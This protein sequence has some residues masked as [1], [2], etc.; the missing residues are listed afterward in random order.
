M[1]PDIRD[2]LIAWVLPSS[3]LQAIAQYYFEDIINRYS[4]TR[5]VTYTFGKVGTHK[6]VLVNPAS[7][8]ENSGI[9]CLV[10][11]L[12][13]HVPSVRAGFLISSDAV[14]PRTG[15]ARIGDIVVGGTL[16]HMQRRIIR[17]DVE[18]TTNKKRL[19]ITGESR[20]MSPSVSEAV[21]YARSPE[22]L[23]DWKRRLYRH[24]GPSDERR[25]VEEVDAPQLAAPS[26]D[27]RKALLGVI[28]SSTLSIEDFGLLA[29]IAAERSILCFETTAA[30]IDDNPFLIVASID[31]YCDD[32]RGHLAHEET[33]KAVVSYLACLVSRIDHYK[34]A[35]EP[36]VELQFRYE[37]FDLGQPGF[38][39]LR[40]QGGTG[41]LQCHIFQAS[42]ADENIVPYEA[43]S[44]CWGSDRL[45]DAIQVNGRAFA[46]TSNLHLALTHLRLPD[47][48]RILWIDAICI[49]QGNIRERGHQ[50][51]H[52]GDVY[53]RAKNVLFWL[54]YVNSDIV[55]LFRALQKFEGRVPVDAWMRWH[56][57][58]T[59]FQGIWDSTQESSEDRNLSRS[60][61]Q[62]RLKSLISNEWFGRVW[63]IQ[64]VFNAQRAS[65]GCT[66][67]WVNARTFA[68]APILLEVEPSTQC[69]AIIDV[70]PGPS[71]RSS[72]WSQKPNLSTLLWKFRE[73]QAT[74]PRDRVFALL[75]ICADRPFKSDYTKTEKA[76]CK[77]LVAYMCRDDVSLHSF[78]CAS[79]A[80]LQNKVPSFLHMD[81]DQLLH[82]DWDHDGVKWFTDRCNQQVFLSEAAFGFLWFSKSPLKEHFVHES[83][84]IHVVPGDSSNGGLPRVTESLAAYLR[85]N[86]GGKATQTVVNALRAS[87]FDVVSMM[88]EQHFDDIE[89]D[90]F[91]AMEAAKR[92]PFVLRQFLKKYGKKVV[93]SRDLNDV[94]TRNGQSILDILLDEYNDQ[95]TITGIMV[96]DA[97]GQ[98]LEAVQLLFNMYRG[99]VEINEETILEAIKYGPAM[100]KL[101]FQECGE[102]MTITQRVAKA[103]IEYGSDTFKFLLDE[104][105]SQ[106][107]INRPVIL[108]AF[109]KGS[110]VFKL[111]TDRYGNQTTSIDELVFEAIR[112]GSNMLE[113]VVDQ[114]CDKIMFTKEMVYELISCRSNMLEFLLDQHSDMVAGTADMVYKAIDSGSHRVLKIV[115]D[116]YSDQITCTNC[117]FRKAFKQG[118]PMVKV[119]LDTYGDQVEIND[120]AD[121]SFYCSADPKALVL[122][123]NRYG[124]SIQIPANVLNTMSRLER[125][126][127]LYMLLDRYGEREDVLRALLRVENR[128]TFWLYAA[129]SMTVRKQ[130]V[131]YP[132]LR[133][134]VTGLAGALVQRSRLFATI[135]A[136]DFNEF[137]LD[138]SLL[139]GSTQQGS[140]RLESIS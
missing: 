129:R 6:V 115:L 53:K 111:L 107:D 15:I 17:L 22:G 24:M 3:D 134:L 21:S 90:G 121:T 66:A 74:E 114:Y 71:R 23:E 96:S 25:G 138:P 97:I 123:F 91:F 56:N 55:N 117:M 65:L 70:M 80:D 99:Q 128:W 51:D 45:A 26:R 2:Y 127:N 4:T 102:Q 47:K 83:S 119:M 27:Q 86:K 38:R 133:I 93:L 8:A 120:I 98:G 43:L 16:Q 39:L 11:D 13:Q 94:A 61:Q 63:V 42:L 132:W 124:D 40:L 44:Y 69:Q 106:L 104:C 19:T 116:H 9:S 81:L 60:S 35:L 64:E 30:T 20:N 1:L 125:N 136:G 52:M 34:L 137:L 82:R 77:D 28:A 12:L 130:R 75:D 89:T 33:C 62:S 105:G 112:Q 14:A 118:L 79:I 110:D 92:G 122:L 10:Q 48:D 85:R 139:L 88:L 29:S 7:N 84:I 67:G 58:D 49:D 95:I 72:W 32:P 131:V 140:P 76:V 50:V 31:K 54:G 73:S 103:A 135:M 37:P 36:S 100:L 59:R 87:D 46:I 101:L 126:D 109:R 113:L 68:L 108:A 18:E 5:H 78:S 41:R 57:E